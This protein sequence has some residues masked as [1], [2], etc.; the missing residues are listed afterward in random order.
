M[1]Q[2]KGLVILCFIVPICLL[3]AQTTTG[4]YEFP[5]KPGTPAWRA[6]KTNA[7]LNKVLQIPENIL[8]NMN[9]KDLLYTCMQ[10]PRFIDM[11]SYDGYKKG[12]MQIRKNFNGFEELLKRKDAWYELINYLDL[13]NPSE[14]KNKTE[15]N[16]SSLKFIELEMIIAQDEIINMISKEERI[17]LLEKVYDKHNELAYISELKRIPIIEPGIYIMGK[18]V[19]IE[20][21]EEFQNKSSN[22]RILNT[23]LN[24]S[25]ML[26]EETI[27]DIT[28]LS[29][30]C[31]NK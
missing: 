30:Q 31:L 18:I 29:K 14:Y 25:L 3:K 6:I 21:A 28:E 4:V 12:F 8:K 20:K 17:K 1:I 19:K 27:N 15:K 23:F 24:T 11:W 10:Y 13:M 9:T 22:N 7:E 2:L 16:F 5:V 26:N